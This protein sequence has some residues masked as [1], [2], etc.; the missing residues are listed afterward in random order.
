M[1][2]APTKKQLEFIEAIEQ[3][4]SAP[5][6]KGKTKQEASDYISKYKDLFELETTST[7]VIENGY[8]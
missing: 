6:F 4:S 8:F 2:E 7:W 3:H 5:I 1:S